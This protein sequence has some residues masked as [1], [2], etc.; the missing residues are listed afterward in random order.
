MPGW[1]SIQPEIQSSG[2]PYEH[3]RR[4]YLKTLAQK[5]GRNVI[6]YYS[7]FLQSH[8]NQVVSIMDADKEGFMNAIQGM[9]KSKGLAL[10]LH[11]PGGDVAAT[12]SIGHY[13][14]QIFG[15]NI[16]CY[17]PQLAMSGGTMLACCCQKIVMGKQSNIGPIDPQFNGIPCYGVLEE[18]RKA[19]QAAEENPKT[20]PIWQT[21][22]GKYH[23]SFIVECEN[24][25][26]LSS[27]I[28]TRWLTTGM[29]AHSKN[30]MAKANKVVTAL[31]DHMTTKVHARHI[32]ADEALNIGLNIVP[33]EADDELQDLVLSIHHAFMSTFWGTNALKIIESDQGKA[34]IINGK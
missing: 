27:E 8:T 3:V 13:L 28:V 18:F 4:A 20:I 7:A 15:T 22:I 9:D 11:T 26:R 30:A 21:I 1:N 34:I 23:P 14:R 31:N 33:L 16:D 19:L 6:A 10:L 12:E 17:I 24:A 2:T 29:F 5:T 32:H 25:I